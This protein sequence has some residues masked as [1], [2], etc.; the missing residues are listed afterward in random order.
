MTETHPRP[1]SPPP[2]RG[3]KT[4]RLLLG[5]MVGG[6]ALLVLG[7]YSF[8]ALWNLEERRGE[9]LV[10]EARRAE[11]EGAEAGAATDE[12][13]CVRLALARKRD[14]PAGEDGNRMF[15][16]ECLRHARRTPGFCAAVPAPAASPE[17]DPWV[18]ARC[19]GGGE[20]C[21]RVMVTVSGYCDHGRQEPASTGS[22]ASPE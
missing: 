17:T 18:Q 3:W 21:Q 22:A 20:R 6:A 7:A 15:T 14:A 1:E 11:A 16:V 13:G 12:A 2:S 19:P 10:A 8:G 4:I 5:G 9:R